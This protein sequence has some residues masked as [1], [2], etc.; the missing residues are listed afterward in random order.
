MHSHQTQNLDE[1]DPS[2]GAALTDYQVNRKRVM[3]LLKS[4]PGALKNMAESSKVFTPIKRS[5]YL[6]RKQKV[7]SED[8]IYICDCVKST[9]ATT[10]QLSDSRLSF[11]CGD[12]CINRMVC[13][14]CEVSTCP[15]AD[16]CQNRKFQQQQDKAVYPFKAGAKGWG[17]LAAETIPHGS[18]VLQ[19][20]GEIFSVKSEEGK[21]RMAACGQS[22]CTYLMK[23]SSKELIDPTFK[24]SIARFINH[25]CEPNCVT[26][27]WNV[28]GEVMVGVFAVKDIQIGDELTFDYKFDVY[29][30]PLSICYCVTPSCRGYLGLR[31]LNYT[32]EE[33]ENKMNNLPCEICKGNYENDDD[34][35][36][37]CDNCNNGFH[38]ECLVPPLNAVPKGAWFCPDCSSTSTQAES[39][40]PMPRQPLISRMSETRVTIERPSEG[41]TDDSRSRKKQQFAEL[42][43]RVLKE[44]DLICQE[45]R[46][47]E[48]LESP[49]WKDLISQSSETVLKTYILTTL[50][51]SLFK[52][53]GARLVAGFPNMRIFWINNDQY[54]RQYFLKQIEVTI[55]CT[56]SQGEIV[57]ELFSTIEE[58]AKNFKES[59]GS[60]E[61]SF[62]IPAIFLKRVLGEYYTNL[63]AVEREFNVKVHFNKKHVTDD[64]FPIH[65]L[66]TIILKSRSENIANAHAHIKAKIA[67]LVVRRKY[68][69][70]CDIKVII[71]RLTYIKKEIGPT[72]IRCNRD[73]ALRD[74]NNPF[75]TIYYKDKEVAFVGT[76]DEVSR[77]ERKVQELIDHNRK[78]DDFSQSL[79]FLIP[80]GEKQVI[81]NIKNKSEKNFPGNKMIVY[82]PLHPRKNSSVTL[83]ST[84]REFDEYLD[85][86]KRQ[87]T[88][89]DF[90]DF[91]FEAYQNQ[92]L[93]QICKHF[94]KSVHNYRQTGSLVFMKQWDIVTAEFQ[95]NGLKTNSLMKSLEH[96]ALND[97]EFVFYYVRVNEMFG[98]EGLKGIGLGVEGL[99][100]VMKGLMAKRL[101]LS[102]TDFTIFGGNR[103]T[104]SLGEEG[105]HTARQSVN[106]GMEVEGRKGFGVGTG[107]AG[108][109]TGESNSGVAVLPFYPKSEPRYDSEY[110]SG[111]Q[112]SFGGHE[113]RHPGIVRSDRGRAS[114]GMDKDP[115]QINYDVRYAYQQDRVDRMR[116]DNRQEDSLG[117]PSMIKNDRE[118]EKPQ[119]SRFEPRVEQR[120]YRKPEFD[121]ESPARGGYDLQP[122]K[123]SR[124]WIRGEDSPHSDR[125]FHNRPAPQ[126]T[127][128][129]KES[130][131]QAREREEEE[132]QSSISSR[133]NRQGSRTNETYD[134]P[135]G[136]Y[137]GD[138]RDYRMSGLHNRQ[139][140]G[141]EI[142]DPRRH[143]DYLPPAAR[144][145]P[146]YLMGRNEPVDYRMRDDYQQKGVRES[147]D[148]RFSRPGRDEPG[149]YH[150]PREAD[151][152][153]RAGDTGTFNK[154]YPDDVRQTPRYGRDT[155]PHPFAPNDSRGHDYHPKQSDN[156]ME[157]DYGRDI[158]RFRMDERSAYDFDQKRKPNRPADD[159]FGYVEY[160]EY[161]R[162]DELGLN[163]RGDFRDVP[164]DPYKRRKF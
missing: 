36:L 145:H 104:R 22:T 54:Y 35:L 135:K 133:Q 58:A 88:R 25:S 87:L 59:I 129:R 156:R 150:Q 100:E 67:E 97:Q 149:M 66:T 6:D 69:S 62:K 102:S 80:A 125:S 127:Q 20:I 18:F 148:G 27:K 8:D 30:T 32:N 101:D 48:R 164:Q 154:G 158:G 10:T 130:R 53:R 12:K 43:A 50:E 84:Y 132:H 41:I 64:C 146:K 107:S 142:R 121:R 105:R 131:F 72:E 61:K 162:T 157:R 34:R 26:Q 152:F 110:R 128:F 114:E 137:D 141:G 38:L 23:L 31:P 139:I 44:F 117:R 82:D 56:K 111:F 153:S 60:V 81:I 42:K 4:I 122:P 76:L 124:T 96:R 77:A 115:G 71:N 95:A 92:F 118:F 91:N 52:E 16:L 7:P 68:I 79:N 99:L 134:Y 120:G 78:T 144:D 163:K 75:Y 119:G 37:V 109:G 28:L 138:R 93:F 126:T 65:Y 155:D 5:I 136:G 98:E 2:S 108:R 160:P 21:K 143:P 40:V 11:D 63:K 161:E 51:L 83:T 46:F 85:Y 17:L 123:A 57:D 112:E 90:P 74:I 47:F 159:R 13:T 24:G 14:E 147:E 29:K 89:K 45:R 116:R 113:K 1:P 55:T 73:N 106:S 3:G 70:R 151:R 9:S 49:E 39:E 94:F 103:T 15:C 86:F 19:Y 140:E 33:W